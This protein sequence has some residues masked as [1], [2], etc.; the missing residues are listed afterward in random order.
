MTRVTL[1]KNVFAK[2]KGPLMMIM[3]KIYVNL[4][5]LG[6]LYLKRKRKVALLCMHNF[7]THRGIN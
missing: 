4:S 7:F 6:F 3:I 1:K 2:K 5:T